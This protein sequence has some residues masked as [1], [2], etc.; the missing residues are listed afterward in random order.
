MKKTLLVALS[1]FFFSTAWADDVVYDGPADWSKFDQFMI[2]RQKEDEITGL[3]YL[4]SG[5][6]ATIGGNLGY[7]SS[8]DSFSRGAY[9]LTQSVGI[10]AIGYGASIYWNGNEF[11]SFYRAVRDSSLSSAQKTELLQRFLSN[12]K[13]QRERT[14][15]IRMG[16]HALLAVVNFYSASQEKDK[17]VKNVF[18]FLGGVNAL[19]AF[20]YAF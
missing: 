15:W 16:T 4:L 5:A 18:Q 2:D 14:R 6:L 13:T 12:E 19:L 7:Y 1:L 17:D 11:D 10:V 20:T 8:S 3:S 9:A